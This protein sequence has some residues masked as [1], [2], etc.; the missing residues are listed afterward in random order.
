M[1]LALMLTQ[2][3]I[4]AADSTPAAQSKTIDLIAD[5]QFRRG[6]QVMAPPMGKKVPEG[7]LAGTNPAAGEPVWQLDQWNSRF[8]IATAMPELLP[9]GGVRY[10]N[11]AKAVTFGRTEPERAD[12]VLRI[13]SNIEYEGKFRAFGQPWPHFLVEQPIESPP[14]DQLA[15]V[16]FHLEARL[17]E[18]KRTT[19][20]G[21]TQD[22]HCGQ[23]P[24]VLTIQNRNRESKGFGDFLWFIV[25]IYDDRYRIVPPHIAKDIADPSAKLIFNPGG[26]FYTKESLHDGRW[27][28]FDKDLLPVIRQSLQTGWDKGF[29]KDSRDLRDYRI[30]STNLGWETTGLYSG[31]IEFRKLSLRA[32]LKNNP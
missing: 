17:V 13:D 18:G 12:L 4:I 6:F 15:A 28:V 31:V 14:L 10:A 16:P 19:G 23:V 25:P 26:D 29:L 2:T 1:I 11:L 3:L 7:R 32:V 30:S 21:Y 27:V 22:L 24:F 5:P 8:S 9:G 20:P